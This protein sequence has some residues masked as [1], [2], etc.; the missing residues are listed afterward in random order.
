MAL[1]APLWLAF[2]PGAWA[3]EVALVGLAAARAVLSVDGGAPRMVVVGASLAGVKLIAVQADSA[4]VEVEGKRRTLRLGE[5]PIRSAEGEAPASG[6][7]ILRADPGGHHLTD[8]AVNGVP[9]RFMVDTG[10][11]FVSLGR[12]DALRAGID[13]SRGQAGFTQTANGPAQVWKVRLDTV[14]VG[15]ITLHDVEGLVHSGDLPVALLGMSF[16]NR[17]EMRREGDA[18][19]LRRRY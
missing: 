6:R 1:L 4:T 16:L 17:M 18:M 5:Q 13:T 10:A 12:A 19:T 7:V 15:G 3:A 8:G 11:T 9:V 2:A 14:R